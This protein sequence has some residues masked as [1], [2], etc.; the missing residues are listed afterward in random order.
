MQ[1]P[2]FQQSVLSKILA[3][4]PHREPS[5][6]LTHHRICS[7]IHCLCAF[8]AYTMRCVGEAGA[9]CQLHHRI[10]SP[11]HC[12]CAF[13][14]YTMECVGEA[15]A[16]HQLRWHIEVEAQAG[17]VTHKSVLIIEF[18]NKMLCGL[19]FAGQIK[20][21]GASLRGFLEWMGPIRLLFFS[22][23]CYSIGPLYK[24]LATDQIN[25]AAAVCRP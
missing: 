8:R 6:T 1:V 3:L 16:L 19:L 13:R 9:L 24:N 23:M 25:A 2:S 20:V 7:A 10:Q 22:V 15:G 5:A 14:A 4:L 12:L 17:R 11:I 18:F 21:C